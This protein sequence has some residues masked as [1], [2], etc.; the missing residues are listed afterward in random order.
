MNVIQAGL[1]FT[2]T[3]E[4]D[5][6]L[7]KQFAY[8]KST[9]LDVTLF[10]QM[11]LVG[12]FPGFPGLGSTG[13]DIV[14]TQSAEDPMIFTYIAEN[15][16]LEGI[17][18]EYKMRADGNWASSLASGYELPASGNNDWQFGTT[19]YPAGTYKLTFTANTSAHTLT[20]QPVLQLTLENSMAE[21]LN[22]ENAPADVTVARTLKAGW[23]AIVL[24]FSLSAEEIAATFGENVEVA[25]FKEASRNGD[26]VHIEFTKAESI[27]AGKP[28]LLHI[29]AAPA[30]A[31]KFEG[32][33]VNFA[34]NNVEGEAFDFVGCFADG[35]AVAGDFIMAG[36]KFKK[37]AG[38]NAINAYRSYLKLKTDGVRSV[39]FYF[40]GVLDDDLGTTGIADMNTDLNTNGG[41]YNLSG[42][43]VTSDGN[44][45]LN[46]KKGVY[47]INGKKVVIK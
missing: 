17:K 32:K 6:Y 20:L 40:D 47:I 39:S 8:D 45:N 16:E 24:P 12:T 22:Y 43:K 27:S 28:C 46:V 3:V 2:V 19:M 1:D 37:A 7:K 9:T 23:N 25:D 33:T 41:I 14:M 34:L 36:G 42:Q 15:V 29:D 35:A 30:V 5:G 13:S 38:G 10:Q 26:D 4:A 31:P 21:A 44:A 11:G 18:Y